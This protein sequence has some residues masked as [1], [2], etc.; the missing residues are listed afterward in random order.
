MD[1]EAL[2][3]LRRHQRRLSSLR[4]EARRLRGDEGATSNASNAVGLLKLEH[5]LCVDM[6][7]VEA[8]ITSAEHRAEGL[9]MAHLVSVAIGSMKVAQDTDAELRKQAAQGEHAGAELADVL[10]QADSTTKRQLYRVLQR[11]LQGA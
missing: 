9:R 2:A 10:A 6:F 1:T 5:G 7:K 8:A 4:T 11:D 3:V